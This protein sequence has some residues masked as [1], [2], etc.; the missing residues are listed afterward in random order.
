MIWLTTNW[1]LKNVECCDLSGSLM[2]GTNVTFGTAFIIV[3]F[4]AGG[5][6]AESGSEFNRTSAS[7]TKMRPEMLVFENGLASIRVWKLVLLALS[8]PS[9]PFVYPVCERPA[10]MPNFPSSVP[11]EIF[12]RK[13]PSPS[14]PNAPPICP[15]VPLF[16][17][18]V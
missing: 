9:I 11:C 8:S 10:V 2:S 1:P 13:R 16:A 15:C 4:D 5:W 18:G 17:S 6:P 3:E 12:P 7:E 14:P